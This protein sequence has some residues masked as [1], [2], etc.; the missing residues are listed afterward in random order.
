MAGAGWSSLPRSR[1]TGSSYNW[2]TVTYASY[3]EL[4][5]RWAVEAGDRLG[6]QVWPDEIERALFEGRTRVET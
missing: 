3:C 5:M 2:H 1:R 6:G 4:L